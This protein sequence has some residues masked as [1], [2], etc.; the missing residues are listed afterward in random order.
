MHRFVTKDKLLSGK[1]N[2]SFRRKL[3]LPRVGLLRE[4]GAPLAGRAT[5]SEQRL[6]RE[7]VAVLEAWADGRRPDKS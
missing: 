4:A 6:D 1:W 3:W 2:T 5:P 7:A